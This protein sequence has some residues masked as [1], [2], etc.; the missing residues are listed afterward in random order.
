[1]QPSLSLGFRTLCL[2]L[3]SSRR[4]VHLQCQL[5]ITFPSMEPPERPPLCSTHPPFLRHHGSW[6]TSLMKLLPILP[7]SDCMKSRFLTPSNFVAS[8]EL[9]IPGEN[10][11]RVPLI[12]TFDGHQYL[13]WRMLRQWLCPPISRSAEAK[14]R[15][16]KLPKRSVR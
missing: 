12:F 6:E 2:A 1:M 3:A 7:H 14:R 13:C 10:P 15:R 8:S 4:S 16:E 9:K 5:F 11:H